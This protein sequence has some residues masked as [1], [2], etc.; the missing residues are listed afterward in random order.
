MALRID[1]FIEMSYEHLLEKDSKLQTIP[2]QIV[3][4]GELANV[5]CRH[6]TF[7]VEHTLP[8]GRIERSRS[9]EG[10]E[11]LEVA[12]GELLAVCEKPWYDQ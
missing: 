3:Q 1:H 4:F 7:N 12:R 6:Q 9:G 2:S 10:I 5:C 11:R 8:F